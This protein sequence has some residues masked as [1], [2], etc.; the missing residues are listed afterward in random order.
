MRVLNLCGRM[1]TIVGILVFGIIGN[2]MADSRRADSDNNIAGSYLITHDGTG[3]RDVITI[4]ADGTFVMTSSDEG[5]FQF[6]SSQGAW[7]RTGRRTIAAK[8]VNFDF[9]DHGVGIVRFDISFD[10]GFRT[11]SGSFTGAVIP[12]SVPDPL[13]ADFDAQFSD[14]FTGRRITA[15]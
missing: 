11:V 5:P 3:S 13:S 10:R 12:D 4:G 8:V 6:S 7:K 2:A 15:E 14:S 9:D 1:L